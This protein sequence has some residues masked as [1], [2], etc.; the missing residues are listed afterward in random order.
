MA[1]LFRPEDGITTRVHFNAVTDDQPPV[2]QLVPGEVG[3]RGPLHPFVVA[4][5][6]ALHRGV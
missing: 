5:H 3:E 1:T 6:R 2:V 4:G